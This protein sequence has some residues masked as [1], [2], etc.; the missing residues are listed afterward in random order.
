MK[1]RMSWLGAVLAAFAAPALAVN[2]QGYDIPYVG[3][4]GTYTI[5][6]SDREWDDGAGY[7]V[8]F[9]MPLR[10]EHFALELS[11]FG[12]RFERDIDGDDD[13]HNGL[14][15]D[16]VRDFG[17][18]SFLSR[19]S[20]RP[21]AVAGIGAVRDDVQ[22]QIKG[23]P[24][25][26]LG[27]GALWGL[28]WW[29]MGV[30]TEFR[31][32]SQHESPSAPDENF[33]FDYRFLL[34]LQIPLT[35][36]FG[37]PRPAEV[38][39]PPECEV[40]VVDP[41]T[42]RTDCITDTDGDGVEDQLDQCPGTPSGA[43]VDDTGCPVAEVMSDGDGDGV[44]DDIDRCPETFEGVTVNTSGCAEPQP[45]VIPRLT[46]E[47]DTERLTPGAREVLDDFGGMLRGQPD[48]TVEIIGHTDSMGS[49][50][51]NQR[52]SEQ[53]AE[54]VK[55][56]LVERGIA[57]ERLSASGRGEGQPVASND[58]EEGRDA[59]RRVAFWLYVD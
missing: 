46:F 9:G 54:A 24:V 31:L 41:V 13:Y 51:Y 6:D 19:T 30:R 28:P 20:M 32:V 1:T 22:G 47:F 17:G 48:L 8:T 5:V 57:D 44:P 2:T 35:P 50:D 36:I 23:R 29:G 53:R 25:A 40:A 12:G 15:V 37:P 39:P 26:N 16:L 18:I 43:P 11:V 33:L 3:A 38:P 4:F 59:N 14:T 45:L 52:L 7:Q 56:H 21:Y 55:Q 58:T 27:G 42:G 49:P 34:G 10:W